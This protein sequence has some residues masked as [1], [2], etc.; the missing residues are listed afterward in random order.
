[1]L[2]E[3]AG[4]VLHERH[5]RVRRV[6]AVQPAD[7]LQRLVAPA[8]AVEQGELVDRRADVVD[9]A[10]GH[11]VALHGRGDVLEQHDV[12]VG[13][14]VVGGVV[15]AGRAHREQPRQIAVEAGLDLVGPGH[16]GSAPTGVVGGGHLGDER[17]RAGAGG[18]VREVESN[19]V[20]DLAGADEREPDV[21]DRGAAR[22]A[23][24][25][26]GAPLRCQV[27]HTGHRRHG[28]HGAPNV[29]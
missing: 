12:G 6:A 25:S 27:V 15:A 8:R 29:A 19:G 1:M 11:L 22:R 17:R 28:F 21:G 20:G 3:R 4:G 10:P 9:R 5:D 7:R 23:G 2:A 13:V 24:E 14:G 18:L 16:P 26:G